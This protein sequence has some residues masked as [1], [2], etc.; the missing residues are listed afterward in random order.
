[1]NKLNLTLWASS[2]VPRPDQ[3]A[4]L[5]QTG[6]SRS[7]T[8][9]PLNVRGL[10]KVV[11]NVAPGKASGY[12]EVF[13]PLNIMDFAIRYT[14]A[15]D[16]AEGLGTPGGYT[17]ANNL[18]ALNSWFLGGIIVK[19]VHFVIRT[20]GGATLAANT[21]KVTKMVEFTAASPD[22]AWIVNNLLVDRFMDPGSYNSIFVVPNSNLAAAANVGLATKQVAFLNSRVDRTHAQVAAGIPSG[23]GYVSAVPFAIDG[24]KDQAW[25]QGTL[26]FRLGSAVLSKAYI[27]GDDTA[28]AVGAAEGANPDFAVDVINK[29]PH[30]TLTAG[31]YTYDFTPKG[32]DACLNVIPGINSLSVKDGQAY[33]I[34]VF[35]TRGCLTAA[36]RVDSNQLT[37]S[38]VQQQSASATGNADGTVL[39]SSGTTTTTTTSTFYFAAASS[40]SMSI[41]VVVA[42][43][44]AII[45]ALL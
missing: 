6:G 2:E 39:V 11:T 15:I 23:K 25:A 16:N 37:V 24:N 28:V 22:S 7:L 29:D 36:R 38:S 44:F 45:A 32:A 20:N 41:S 21:N 14:V 34:F 18:A 42:A 31:D 8:N 26:N 5:S 40:V 3:L 19:R 4:E 43:L 10:Y 30:F 33:D 35:N 13:V 17:N 12:G 27:A 1:L 9:H